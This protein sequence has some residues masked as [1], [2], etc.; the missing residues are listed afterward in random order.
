MHFGKFIVDFIMGK[1]YLK[2]TPEDIMIKPYVRIFIQQF[3]VIIAFF[4]IVFNQV[5]II[6]AILIITFRLVIDLTLEVIRENS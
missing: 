3:V 2:F 5:G 4:F 1:K 6:V